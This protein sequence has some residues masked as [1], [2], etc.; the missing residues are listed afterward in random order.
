MKF[1]N[2]YQPL[3]S[4]YLSKVDVLS[5]LS[6]ERIEFLVVFN[7][8]PYYIPVLYCDVNSVSLACANMSSVFFKYLADILLFIFDNYRGN[9]LNSSHSVPET[10]LVF[11]FK[12]TCQSNMD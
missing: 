8:L 6:A 11:S 5:S 12:Y 7:L 1:V 4:R 9:S 2:F 10:R 3:L